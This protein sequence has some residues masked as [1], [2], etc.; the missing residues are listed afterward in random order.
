MAKVTKG[1]ELS[2]RLG[3]QIG[4][5]ADLFGQL[6]EADVN[7]VASCCYQIAG[8]AYFSIVPDDMDRASEV[9]SKSKLTPDERDVLLV[10][11]PNKTGAFAKLLQEISE[12]G[13]AVGSAY[14][15]TMGKKSALAV[16]KTDNDDKV[17]EALG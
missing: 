12:L 13:V 17:V 16:L 11:L 3:D 14:A 7:V 1:K 6:K 10:E 4:A 2:V 5:G 8:E 15:T 9:L